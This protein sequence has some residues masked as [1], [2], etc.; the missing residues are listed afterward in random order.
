MKQHCRSLEFLSF[1]KEHHTT[2]E[3]GVEV[4]PAGAYILPDFCEYCEAT[5]TKQC[6]SSCRRPKLFFAKKRPPFCNQAKMDAD[7]WDEKK[8]VKGKEQTEGSSTSWMVGLFGR[9]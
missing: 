4:L 7:W 8:N 3:H 1:F 6:G 5:S 9:E 2:N